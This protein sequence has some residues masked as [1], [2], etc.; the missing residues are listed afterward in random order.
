MY[1]SNTS[2]SDGTR[3]LFLFFVLKYF[4]LQFDFLNGSF[5]SAH[6]RLGCVDA[7][8]GSITFK[9]ININ[10]VNGVK[11]GDGEFFESQ[12][13][14]TRRREARRKGKSGSTELNAKIK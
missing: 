8:D 4:V 5:L 10:Y 6:Y 12:S 7:V 3:A 2:S 14:N 9:S 1:L 11:E 13:Q